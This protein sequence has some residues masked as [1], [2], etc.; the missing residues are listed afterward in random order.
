MPPIRLKPKKHVNHNN[1]NA[2]ALALPISEPN[3]RI[4]APSLG[5]VPPNDGA[6]LAVL[7]SG[8]NRRK[9]E[10]GKFKLKLLDNIKDEVIIKT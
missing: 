2:P 5:P 4:K 7:I 10:K 8:I 9:I 6:M 1:A 3:N